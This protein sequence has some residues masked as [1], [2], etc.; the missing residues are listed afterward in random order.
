MYIVQNV[1]NFDVCPHY[2][3]RKCEVTPSQE[4]SIYKKDCLKKNLIIPCMCVVV[5]ISM[6]CFGMGTM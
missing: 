3:I 1:A 4:F 2:R 5:E 6:K